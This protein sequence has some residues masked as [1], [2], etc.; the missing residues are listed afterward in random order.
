MTKYNRP[1]GIN[2][3]ATASPEE[4]NAT[5]RSVAAGG[6]NDGG[7]PTTAP[8]PAP[9]PKPQESRWKPPSFNN[10]DVMPGSG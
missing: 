7:T 4:R 1:G 9:A 2:V 8:T 3:S 5:Y 10:Q 6:A